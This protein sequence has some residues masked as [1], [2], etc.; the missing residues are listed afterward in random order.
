MQFLGYEMITDSSDIFNVENGYTI[1]YSDSL[2]GQIIRYI[3][4]FITQKIYG[5]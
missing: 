2:I 1:L 5:F 3:I 4:N